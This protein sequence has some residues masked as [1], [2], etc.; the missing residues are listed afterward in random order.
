MQDQQGSEG[1]EMLERVKPT[2]LRCYC[3]DKYKK[4]EE[5]AL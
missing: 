5:N 2:G 3:T 4:T 1:K